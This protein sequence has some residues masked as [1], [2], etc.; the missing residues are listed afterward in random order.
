M[1]QVAAHDAIGID[2]QIIEAPA[3]TGCAGNRLDTL[4]DIED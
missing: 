2:D 3:T 4:G 1:H